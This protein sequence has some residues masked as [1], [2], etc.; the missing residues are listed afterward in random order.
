MER[1]ERTQ[2]IRVE[3][4]ELLAALNLITECENER[5]TNVIRIKRNLTCQV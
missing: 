5:L 4:I 2:S 1:I 3:L